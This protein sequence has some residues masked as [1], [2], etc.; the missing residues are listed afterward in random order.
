MP[1]RKRRRLS[2]A[3]P[4]ISPVAPSNA[5]PS[6]IDTSPSQPS[7]S[8]LPTDDAI[9]PF[10]NTTF[11]THRVSPLYVGSQPLVQGRLHVLSQRLRD[12]LVGD[13]VRGV[14]VGLDRAADDGAMRRA[15]ALEVVAMG[16]VRLE[17]LVGRYVGSEGGGTPP[18]RR[19]ALQISMQYENTECAALLLPTLQARPAAG[20]GRPG[21]EDHD[22]LHLPL[23]LLRM[24]G[25][26]KTVIIDFVSRT[27][28]CRI[29][30]LSLGTRSL[31][32]ALERWIS[33][34]EK[35]ATDRS[36]RDVSLTL[37]FYA[38]A[39]A[40]LHQGQRDEGKG[41]DQTEGNEAE[42]GPPPATPLGIK[43]I[44]VIIPHTDL[45]RFLRVGRASEAERAEAVGQAAGKQHASGSVDVL[46][47]FGSVRRKRL[48]GGKDEES[49]AWRSWDSGLGQPFTEAL[50][51]YVWKH[52]AL[53]MFHPAVRVTKIAC[54]GF[55]LSES[56]VKIFV[57]DA[58]SDTK[59]RAVW[60]VVGGLLDRA[61]N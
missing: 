23:L 20:V 53:D 22:F 16:W 50:G 11:S 46:D 15:G 44:D 52:L 48:G 40:Q 10:L 58:L 14:E 60:A 26:L 13:V 59:Q 39:V 56:R 34:A 61:D 47:T 51:R 54:E 36:T 18:G 17:N 55:V 41:Q 43:S 12:L 2:D 37:G 32:G 6:G 35:S 24:P 5:S 7:T 28:D 31:V 3:Q 9:P 42:D 57:D 21:E 33:H 30:S 29:S 49:W 1:P 45:R 19:R 38:P 27:F 4:P 25:P 8:S